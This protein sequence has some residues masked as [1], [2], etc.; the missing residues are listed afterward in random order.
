MGT[1]SWS[2]KQDMYLRQG[3]SSTDPGSQGQFSQQVD[4]IFHIREAEI[5]PRFPGGPGPHGSFLVGHK[6]Y[7]VL[8]A[9][10]L[11]IN[12][13]PDLS[14]SARRAPGTVSSWGATEVTDTSRLRVVHPL[15]LGGA[16]QFDGRPSRYTEGVAVG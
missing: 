13:Q 5:L 9:N 14:G 11:T 7:T 10:A 6:V 1:C 16:S 15:Q 2:I 3:P 4:R 12:K 8:L